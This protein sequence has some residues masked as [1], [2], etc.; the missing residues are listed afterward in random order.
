MLELQKIHNP[1]LLGKQRNLSSPT[2]NRNGGCWSN[3]TLDSLALCTL[4]ARL[5]G[6]RKRTLAKAKH[7]SGDRLGGDQCA[8][9]AHTPSIHST[10]AVPIEL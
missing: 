6:D 10:G 5:E 7:T 2:G 3:G 1:T 8:H 4:L 9:L